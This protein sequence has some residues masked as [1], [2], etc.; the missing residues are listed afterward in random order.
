MDSTADIACTGS[1]IDSIP[2]TKNEICCENPSFQAE[3]HS[4]LEIKELLNKKTKQLSEGLSLLV[5]GIEIRKYANELVRSVTGIKS[6]STQRFVWQELLQVNKNADLDVSMLNQKI[7]PVLKFLYPRSYVLQQQKK[8]QKK[9]NLYSVNG[10]K[11]KKKLVRTRK[12]Q[13]DQRLACASNYNLQSASSIII[14]VGP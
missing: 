14:G 11:L 6:E 4:V 3:K 7:Q 8:T 2:A 10:L 13:I 1:K 9:S 5:S 12:S